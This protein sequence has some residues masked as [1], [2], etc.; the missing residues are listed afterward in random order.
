VFLNYPPKI[1]AS[2]RSNLYVRNNTV[3]GHAAYNF[4]D[5]MAS[6]NDSG[7]TYTNLQILSWKPIEV[8][9]SSSIMRTP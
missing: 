5:P 3:E 9:K 8:V 6:P 4:R 1:A 2:R 7:G